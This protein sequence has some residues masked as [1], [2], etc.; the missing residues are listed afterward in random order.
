MFFNQDE[1]EYQVFRIPAFLTVDQERIFYMVYAGDM[2]EAFA[3]TSVHLFEDLR[4]SERVVYPDSLI[5]C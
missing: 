3:F 2:P 5:S 4:T 1:E